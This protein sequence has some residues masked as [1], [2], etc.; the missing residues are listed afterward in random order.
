M[1]E[2]LWDW[3]RQ[4][5]WQC[6]ED[7]AAGAKFKAFHKKHKSHPIEVVDAKPRKLMC[8]INS[9]EVDY[10]RVMVRIRMSDLNEA[11]KA[12]LAPAQH[13]ETIVVEDDNG[14]LQC[15]ITPY[16]Q[17]SAT[18]KAAALAALDQMRKKSGKTM[19]DL[20]IT[21]SDV[22]RELQD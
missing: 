3:T 1:R 17:A 10:N 19:I 21:E 18:E 9:K 5:V 20:G 13:G 16:V 22:D 12:F 14:T 15:G 7:K 6:R 8:W 11:V 2:K 4:W